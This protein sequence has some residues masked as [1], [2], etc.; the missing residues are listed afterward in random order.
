MRFGLLQTKVGLIYLLK[1]FEIEPLF[2][3]MKPVEFTST[4][5]TLAIKDP[6]KLR[7]KK[8]TD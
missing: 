5:I 2:E 4:N 8:R 6:L 7:I 3:T 1:N